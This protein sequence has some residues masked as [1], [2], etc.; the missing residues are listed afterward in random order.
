MHGFNI[1]FLLQL[2]N[3]PRPTIGY[4]PC[5]CGDISRQQ[6]RANRLYQSRPLMCRRRRCVTTLTNPH[7][8]HAGRDHH[9]GGGA[10]SPRFTAHCGVLRDWAAGATA[11]VRSEL[12]D[13]VGVQR[14]GRRIY[15]DTVSSN[16]ATEIHLPRV[17]KSW[18]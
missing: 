18:L 9:P 6:S 16:N 15:G 7:S 8:P 2:T 17:N 13:L 5:P 12:H 11:M 4:R 1:L 10:A 14:G 3:V